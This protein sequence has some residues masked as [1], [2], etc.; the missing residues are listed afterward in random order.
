M[1]VKPNQW[2]GAL[3]CNFSA[4]D[5]HVLTLEE[6]GVLT[7]TG[8]SDKVAFNAT[9][10]ELGKWSH[11]TLSYDGEAARLY[12]NNQL[13]GEQK[14]K[15]LTLIPNEGGWYIEPCGSIDEFRVWDTMLP[16]D[17]ERFWRNTAT[18]YNPNGGSSRNR[19]KTH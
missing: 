5:R 9:G 6:A 17:Y 3:L 19:V 10:I 16:E 18:I 11:I 1:W 7:L 13:A 15:G 2:G 4:L 12:V 8:E 14:S